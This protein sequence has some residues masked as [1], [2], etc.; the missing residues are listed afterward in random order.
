MTADSL[1]LTPDTFNIIG[2][3]HNN[4]LDYI[5][6]NQIANNI[7]SSYED[8][9]NSSINYMFNVDENMK[10]TSDNPQ[11]LQ[12]PEQKELTRYIVENAG[13]LSMSEIITILRKH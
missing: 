10:L 11:T 8:I 6:N 9:N 4:A 13:V 3:T 7:N 12:T 5:Y 2:E 1:E